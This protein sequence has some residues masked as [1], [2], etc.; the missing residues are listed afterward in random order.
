MPRPKKEVTTPSM[1][2]GQA[3]YVLERMMR[4]RRISAGDV[5]RYVGDM[6]REISELESRLNSLRGSLG[7]SAP[8]AA[9]KRGPGRP[10]GRPA[11]SGTTKRRRRGRPAKKAAPVAAAAPA[12]AAAAPA[13]A[14]AAKKRGRRRKPLTAEVRASQQLQ[15]KYLALIRQIP[16]SKRGQYQKMAKE[17]GREAAIKEMQSAVK[18]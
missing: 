4:D 3:S 17:K 1:S 11:G 14:P 7:S 6:H 12:P 9:A 18:K 15:G 13:A 16:A 8:A 2:P 10:P 5:N